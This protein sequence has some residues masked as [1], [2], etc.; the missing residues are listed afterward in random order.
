[1]NAH[2]TAQELPAGRLATFED[3]DAGDLA[4]ILGARPKTPAADPSAPA[5]RTAQRQAPAPAKKSAPKK[6]PAAKAP[7]AKAPTAPKY[8]ERDNA[9]RSSS[10]HIPTPLLEQVVVYR[11]EHGMSNGQVVIAA[12]EAAHP[13][14]KDLIHPGAT[15]GGLFAQRAT[16]GIRAN[17][18]PLTPLNVRLFEADFAV[19]DRLVEEFGA[20]SRGHLV[21]ESLREFFTR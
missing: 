3:D 17:D 14:L 13:K 7:A 20:F 19:I 12:I 5:D 18:G 6:A 2:G 1:M 10:I 9:I 11:D 8:S 16:K 4:S 21:T 15:G